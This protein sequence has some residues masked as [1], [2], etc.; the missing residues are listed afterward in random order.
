MAVTQIKEIAAFEHDKSVK[1]LSH[2]MRKLRMELQQELRNEMRYPRNSIAFLHGP[3]GSQFSCSFVQPPRRDLN[4]RPMPSRRDPS[5]RPRN[6]SS[7]NKPC[8]LEPCLQLP[9][10]RIGDLHVPAVMWWEHLVV[11][12]N[13]NLSP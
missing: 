3:Q 8:T 4:P 9:K 12:Y 13:V 1:D 11:R 6:S 10:I 2:K 7:Y 5:P